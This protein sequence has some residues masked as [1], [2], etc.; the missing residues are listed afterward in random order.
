MSSRIIAQRPRRTALAAALAI[1]LGFTG[2][3]VGQST[4]GTIFGSA[5][6]G[7]TVTVTST[8][9]VT[10]TVT[11]DTSGRY[12]ASHLPVGTYTVTLNNG[13]ETVST[14]NNVTIAVGAGTQVDFGSGGASA[15]ELGA[16]N[17]NA[18]ALPSIDV[19]SVSSSFTVT[20]QQLAQLPVARNAESIA[21]LAPGVVSG[22]QYFGRTVTFAGA[23][24]T[25]NAY[26]VNG[27]NTTQLYTFTGASYQLPYGAI[28]QQE[29]LVGGYSAKYGRADGGVINQVGKRGTNQWHFG[30]QAVWTPRSLRSNPKN[31]D[32]PNIE[33]Q[34]GEGLESDQH[35]PGDL[36]QYR[37]D[38]K[39]WETQYAAYVGGPIIQDKLFFYL[40]AQQTEINNKNV[41]SVGTG[42]VDYLKSHSTNW[43][44]KVDWNIDENNILE[45]TELKEDRTGADS[46]YG[47]EYDYDNDTNT[48]LGNGV[49]LPFDH[50]NTDTKIFHYTSYLTDAATL[51]VLYGYTNAENPSELPGASSLPY[52]S[53]A[54]NQDPSI[55]GGTTI[56][57]AQPAATVGSGA[58]TQRSK[59][60]RVDLDYQLGDHLLEVGIDNLHYSASD[61]GVD[62]TGPGYYWVYGHNKDPNAPINDVLNVGAPGG[63]GYYV[64]R[65]T[66]STVTSMSADQ[67]A[68][69]VQDQWQ[70]TDN[71]LLS[72]GIRNDHFSNSNADNIKFVDEKNQWEPRLGF[73]W[74]VSGDSS[75]KIYGNVG[76]Y[77]LALPQAT[78]ERA[79]SG[80][81]YTNNY[82]T[83]TGIDANG[84]PTGLAPVRGVGGGPAPGEVSSNNE[85]GQAPDPGAVTAT[86]LKPQYQDELILGFDKTWGP[87]WVYGAKFTYRTLGTLIDDECDPYTLRGVMEKQGYNP[88]DYLWDAPYCRLFNPNRSNTYKVNS[89]TGGDPVY[90]SVSQADYKFPDAQRDYYALDLYLEH[91]FD[92]TWMGRVDYTFARSW[93]NTEGQVRSDFGQGDISVTEDWDYW[94]LMDHAR[95]YLSNHRR[96]Q[97]KAYGAWQV[98][99]EW[100]LSGTL[101]VQSGAP[102]ECLGT[103]GTDP[104]NTNPGY[105]YGNH[106]HWCRGMPSPPGEQTNPWTKRLDLAVA[107]RP[108]FADNKLAFKLDVFN[109]T[110]EQEVLQTYPLLH[111]RFG[112]TTTIS[113][114]YHLPL[115]YQTPRYVRFS[116]S[117]DY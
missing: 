6:A 90:V 69:Y 11:A 79:A 18:S 59:S 104:D 61:Q 22:S 39:S 84:E 57:N 86:N 76:R 41:Y 9:G 10:R 46:Y 103:F 109:V 91:P 44:G 47:V 5:P 95:G 115:F 73:S 92:G 16:V 87:D 96:H 51:S 112:D 8:S 102:V 110:N 7:Q 53:G 26:Y 82:Y 66:Y 52:I 98:T 114:T 55:T 70:V 65:L 58:A 14:R 3:A 37:H 13:S 101:L 81:Y 71:L 28:E 77:Y 107:Y 31:T 21:L 85:F 12:S 23:G 1:G 111:P 45:F 35:K 50:Y 25:E 42:K 20:A 27:Y 63:D 2:A 89:A 48:D 80:S 75:L 38:N 106:Y 54:D 15:Q 105:G 40:A 19:S 24:A 99:P 88:D 34:P 62:S 117:Y 30:A 72:L 67:K 94:Q 32:Y 68:W 97:L 43:Y 33:L 36:Y 17:V 29:N 100:L 108:N 113:N 60:L 78:G 93:G 49:A 83:Y 116:I 56:R 74:D 64:S 4:S